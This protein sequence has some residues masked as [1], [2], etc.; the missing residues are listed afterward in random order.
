MVQF[1]QLGLDERIIQA[2]KS[3]GYVEPTPIQ[4]AIIPALLEGRDVM[5][6]AQ[7]GTG[8]TAAYVLPLLHLLLVAQFVL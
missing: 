3:E 4:A 2:T 5:G 1:S 7:T 6:V 8:K